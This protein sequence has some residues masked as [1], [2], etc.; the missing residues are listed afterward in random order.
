MRSTNDD[1]LSKINTD[2]IIANKK[3][4]TREVLRINA[5]NT[6]NFSFQKIFFS[7]PEKRQRIIWNV[8]MLLFSSAPK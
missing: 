6:T 4:K 5:Q 2:K 3:Q 1:T 7:P 8:Y